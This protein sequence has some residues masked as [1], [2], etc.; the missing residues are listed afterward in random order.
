MAR[1][2]VADVYIGGTFVR[3]AFSLDSGFIREI[4]SINKNLKNIYLLL[5]GLIDVHTH[6]RE[7]GFLYKENIAS[8][9]L[10]GAR[11]G[12]QHICS[13]PN[14]NP[15][16]DS[17]ESLKVQTDIINKD[18]NINVYPYATITKGQKGMEL[19]DFSSLK[20]KVI[21]FS[22]DG[23]GVQSEELMLKAMIE[24][25]EQNAMIVAHCE[26]NSLLNGGYIHDGEYC[27]N[28]NHKGISSASEYMQIKRDISLA[29]KSG[30]KYH[31]CHIS[32][33]ESVDLIRKA[34]AE[35]VDIS[36]ETAPHYLTLDDSCLLDEGR[37]KMN[38]PLRSS[39]DKKA[40]IEGIID[41][42]IDMIAT[43]HAPHSIDEKS[44]GL[45][46]SNM[47]IVGIETSFGVCYT[48]LVKTGIIGLKK[49]LKLMYENPKKRFNIGKD[50][51]E[52]FSDFVLFDIN[53][54]YE[55]D[56][57]KFLSKGKATPFEGWTLYGD[58]VL[59]V[60]NNKIIWEKK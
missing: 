26:D 41:G 31:V 13:M 7:P 35:G 10:A 33:K 15:C 27:K 3:K 20:N 36:C 25:K 58:C 46:G 2:F 14:L 39:E 18:S 30:V 53:N 38:P 47:G 45:A 43:D 34:K 52:N 32:T 44:K 19:V 56:S 28:N 54:S 11:G 12:F 60:I 1:S 48:H 6:L 40:L 55:V 51:D 9:T 23:V 22:D 4:D 21:G 5:P 8:G 16:P 50:L 24:A 59:N 37:F 42:T 57:S 29:K 17:I 49:L